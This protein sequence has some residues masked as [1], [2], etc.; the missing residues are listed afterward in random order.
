MPQEHAEEDKSGPLDLAN[1]ELSD[2]I[3]VI[4]LQW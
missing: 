1:V 2:V 3:D 4:A